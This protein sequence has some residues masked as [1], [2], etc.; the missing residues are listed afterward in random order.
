VS[1]EP[2]PRVQWLNHYS[3]PLSNHLELG[4]L[5]NPKNHSSTLK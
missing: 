1:G 5:L 2:T 4:L 3:C